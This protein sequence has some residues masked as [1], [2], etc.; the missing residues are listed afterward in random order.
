M[1]SHIFWIF[2]SYCIFNIVSFDSNT[3]LSDFGKEYSPIDINAS[4]LSHQIAISPMKCIFQCHEYF[5]CQIFNYDLNTHQCQLFEG[6]LFS[7][8]SIILSS[9]TTSVVGQILLLQSNF[10]SYNQS[11][12][13]CKDNRF[14]RCINNKCV[15][16]E[17]TYW[18]GTFCLPQI[19]I[20]NIA[21]Q[22]DMN[23]CRTDLDLTCQFFNKCVCK[24]I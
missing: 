4:L 22:Q 6:D 24:S 9:S 7:T 18:N 3:I 8:G 10:K 1:F 11:C 21:C 2:I 12:N 19:V 17:H 16:H 5:R 20:P 15:C 14:L 13:Q 23:M